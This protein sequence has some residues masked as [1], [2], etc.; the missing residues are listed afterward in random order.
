MFYKSLLVV[1]LVFLVSFHGKSQTSAPEP[2]VHFVF[3]EAEGATEVINTGSNTAVSAEIISEGGT[4]SPGATDS[5]F[6]QV[7]NVNTDN[8]GRIILKNGQEDFGNPTGGAARTFSLWMKQPV[9]EFSNLVVTG[10]NTA[11]FTFQIQTNGIVRLVDETGNI[12]RTTV[13]IST[14][15][16]QHLAV[17]FPEGGN[18]EDAQIF[19]NGVPSSQTLTGTNMPIN[20]AT[21]AVRLFPKCV[22]CSISDFRY[23]ASALTADEIKAIYELKAIEDPN[24][25]GENFD[26]NGFINSRLD[27]GETTVV[28]PP[29]RYRVAPIGNSVYHVLLRDRNNVTIIA[30]G[31]EM[32]C[33]ETVQAVRIENCTNLKLQGLSVDYDPLPFTQGR[34]VNISSNQLTLTVD[35]IDGYSTTAEGEKVEIYD[36]VTGELSARTY[37]GATLNVD[38]QA[39]RVIISK[40]SPDPNYVEK[41]GDIVVIDSR[42]NRRIPHTI[43]PQGCT[44]L[45][46][47]NVTV[48]AG[49][50]FAFFETNSN[51]SKYINCSVDRRPLE[52]DIKSRG[53]RRMRSNNADAFHSKHAEVGPSYVG[54]IA[55]Y[56]GD[57]SYAI[58]GDFHIISESNGN[59]LTVIPKGGGNKTPNL[60]VGEVVE[61]VSYSGERLPDAMVTQVER[62]RAL[63]STEYNFIDSRTSFRAEAA[64]SKTANN[65]YYVTI[66]RSVDLPLGSLINSAARVGNGFEVRDCIAGPNRSRGILVKASHGIITGNTLV[67]NWIQAIKCSPEY[68]WLEAGSGND[69][70]ISNNV[71]TGCHTTA[72]NVYAEAGDGS[73]PKAGAHD[74]I[75]I[76]NNQ[77]SDSPD[78]KIYVSSTTNLVLD[79]ENYATSEIELVNVEFA[80]ANIALAKPVTVSSA[81]ESA[82]NLVDNNESTRWSAE[83]FPQWAEIDLGADYNI[84]RLDLYPFEERDYQYIIEVKGEEA[85]TYSSA[86]DRSVNTTEAQVLRDNVTVS[87][88]YVKITVMGAN[89]YTGSLVELNE[90]KIT[91]KL[92][93][94]LALAPKSITDFSIFPNPTSDI[95]NLVNESKKHANMQLLD[96]S[97]R[98]ILSQT[99]SPGNNAID[100]TSLNRGV[101]FIRII[102]GN[103]V[104][105]IERIVKFD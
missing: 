95:L 6:G 74:D 89:T 63:N 22:D 100:L 5:D 36:P 78:P 1:S 77:I 52:T 48:F 98:S 76:F 8:N 32:I 46:L 16:W 34:I 37:Y 85:T 25:S 54:C 20:T 30:D 49:T 51:G 21:G 40:G 26:L 12:L 43:T 56:N 9:L 24:D 19:V 80:E 87:G 68:N 93:T 101:Y 91:G 35:L 50:S 23:Y 86:V 39:R 72:I 11:G 13:S 47:E 57:D 99:L 59:I 64:D 90:L 15:V 94:P 103:R 75:R 55:R 73:I 4:F 79:M 83:T 14:N 44:N 81:S 41:V 104:I 7:L 33:T 97:G 69:I 45:T 92:V 17:T 29:G 2:N 84:T 96:A 61:L 31:V 27:A 65:V 102:D 105:S 38:A 60:E 88:R 28:V 42:G 66:D 67:D 3:D 71:I 18:M 62:G 70:E 82:A 58:N 10:S 53:V